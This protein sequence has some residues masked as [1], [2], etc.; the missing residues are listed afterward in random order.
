MD[1]FTGLIYLIPLVIAYLS[2]SVWMYERD[3][4]SKNKRHLALISA[5]CLVIGMYLLMYV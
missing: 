2:F 3:R 5:T 4:K 1:S